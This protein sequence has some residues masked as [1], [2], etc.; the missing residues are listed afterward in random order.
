MNVLEAIKL[1]Q[2][3]KIVRVQTEDDVYYIFELVILPFN[4]REFH[5]TTLWSQKTRGKK[6]PLALHNL[7]FSSLDEL[8]IEVIVS[9]DYNV[10][11]PEDVIS[12]INKSWIDY[13]K[14]EAT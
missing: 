9:P 4:K 8:S 5:I 7:R 11:S 6:P 3:G 14:Q 10:V 12:E 13:N 1:V 2:E